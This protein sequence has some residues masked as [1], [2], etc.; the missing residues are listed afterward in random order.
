MPDRMHKT[1]SGVGLDRRHFLTLGGSL[2]ASAAVAACATGTP[3]GTAQGVVG[4]ELR[5][6]LRGR[7]ILPGDA[8]FAQAQLPWNLAVDQSVLAVAE[9]ADAADAAQL[10]RYARRAGVSVSTQPIGHG[11]AHGLSGTILVRTGRLG[12]VQVDPDKQSA[13][14]GA[15]VTWGQVQEQAGQY[16]LAGLSGSSPAVSVVGYTLGGG[17]SWFGRKHGWAANSVTAFECVD[18]DGNR[19]K[20]TTN[21]EADLFWALRGGGG[22]FALVTAVEFDLHPAPVVYGGRMLWPARQAA[23]V[24]AAYRDVTAAAPDELTVWLELMQP[25]GGGSSVIGVDATYLGDATEGEKLL[26]QFDQIAGRLSDTR[27]VL[28]VS[29]LGSITAEPTKPARSI[30]HTQLLTVLDDNVVQQLLAEPIAPLGIQIRHF[31]GAYARACDIPPGL[32]AEPYQI[33]FRGV[34]STPQASAAIQTRIQEFRSTLGPYLAARTPFTF[35]SA[36]QTAASAVTPDALGRLRDIK[37]RRDPHNVFH[38]NFPV[39]N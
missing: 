28:P 11:A 3:S 17:L 26:R 10:V 21:S 39:L 36:S 29:A 35:L 1:H 31:G 19:I 15:G 18:A 24:L 2:L 8:G 14:V 16:L 30:A 38:S 6:A 9:I 12:D 37:R 32:I 27:A 7:V 23:P 13:R 33:N 4:P 20:A 34:A 22:D 5:G 25:P